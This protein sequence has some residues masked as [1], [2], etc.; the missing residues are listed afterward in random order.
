MLG[1]VM[2]ASKEL[3]AALPNIH[4]IGVFITASTLV[5]GVRALYPLYTFVFLCGLFG[6]FNLWWVPYLYVWTVLWGAVMGGRRVLVKSRLRYPFL[7]L[8]CGLHGLLFGVLYA[9]F[10]AIVFGLNFQ[11]TL[12]WIGAGLPFDVTHGISNLLCSLVLVY[13]L[14]RLMKRAKKGGI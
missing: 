3:M 8:L 1:G 6:G 9:P 12:A 13:P 4:L 7:A 5:Y 2:Y 14:E 11:Q 10:Q